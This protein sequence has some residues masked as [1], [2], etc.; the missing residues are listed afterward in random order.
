MRHFLSDLVF[1]YPSYL[2]NWIITVVVLRLCRVLPASQDWSI[3]WLATLGMVGGLYLTHV[4]PR[5]ISTPYFGGIC[6][7][8]L[9]LVAADLLS[10]TLP[11]VAV[12]AVIR[13]S[14]DRHTTDL[15]M[16]MALPLVFM[17]FNDPL[18][19]YGIR[20]SDLGAIVALSGVV[21]CGLSR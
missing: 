9:P 8:G 14:P 1:W 6:L 19:R 7:K 13:R 12:I 3:L 18:R 16:G 5:H 2:T 21:F 11:A 15:R 17:M 10:H 4:Y 20:V